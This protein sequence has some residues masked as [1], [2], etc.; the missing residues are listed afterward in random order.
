MRPLA[1]TELIYTQMYLNK[2]GAITEGERAIVR[3]IGPSVSDTPR[4]IMAKAELIK[5]RGRFDMTKADLLAQYDEKMKS[6]GKRPTV[7]GFENTP[8]Y[9][10]LF[11]EYDALSDKISEKYFPVKAKK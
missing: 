7:S 6:Q 4:V 11:R 10:E 2:Q 3:N 9:R 1:E 5:A 8:E